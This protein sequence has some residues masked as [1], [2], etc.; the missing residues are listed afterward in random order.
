MLVLSPWEKTTLKTTKI[1]NFVRCHREDIESVPNQERARDHDEILN[2]PMEGI[3]YGNRETIISNRND[4]PQR[5][6]LNQTPATTCQGEDRSNKHE[7]LRDIAIKQLKVDMEEHWFFYIWPRENVKRH[8]HLLYARKRDDGS[9]TYVG[10]A[11]YY[12][13]LRACAKAAQVDVRVMHICNLTLER[14]IGWIEK[15]ID[16]SLQQ[17]CVNK[18]DPDTSVSDEARESAT[19]YTF[20]YDKLWNYQFDHA[21]IDLSMS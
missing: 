3:N 9:L 7:N 4:V 6:Q 1:L 21:I 15:K 11:D 14:R 18:D 13:I 12:I 17:L 8:G 19:N 10:H 5:S 20:W 2:T 16:H